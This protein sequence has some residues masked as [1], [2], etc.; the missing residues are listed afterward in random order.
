MEDTENVGSFDC[1]SS[2]DA[3]APVVLS[4]CSLL[5]ARTEP[6]RVLATVSSYPSLS[7]QVRVAFRALTAMFGVSTVGA[8]VSVRV[9][10]KVEPLMKVGTL[11]IYAIDS[12]SEHVPTAPPC[13]GHGMITD[14]W[15]P[16]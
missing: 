5:D 8:R 6:I 16:V 3:E 13:Q 15:V 2:S 11:R 1:E 14:L 12:S 4:S 10:V 9:R 7:F